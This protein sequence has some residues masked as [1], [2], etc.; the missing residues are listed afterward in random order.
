MTG[1]VSKPWF[2][3]KQFGYGAG[4]PVAWQGWVLLLS[5]FGVV[6]VIIALVSGLEQSLGIFGAT[7][8]FGAIAARKTEGGW[9]WRWGK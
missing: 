1:R 7:V 6:L 5:F 4:W 3:P 9:R 8:I 2:A